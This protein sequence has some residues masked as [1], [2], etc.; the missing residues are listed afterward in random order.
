MNSLKPK[1]RKKEKKSKESQLCKGKWNGKRFE[2][3]MWKLAALM[4]IQV[5]VDQVVVWPKSWLII[6]FNE[7]SI[8]DNWYYSQSNEWE[9]TLETSLMDLLG[10]TF[11]AE[12]LVLLKIIVSLMRQ[13]FGLSLYICGL[14][15]RSSSL[16]LITPEINEVLSNES[17]TCE[18]LKEADLHKIR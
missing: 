8:C 6:H 11:P 10:R 15:L 1:E 17:S 7:V 13:P 5:M 3:K 18:H 12:R 4:P 14:F 16:D 2:H 9:R